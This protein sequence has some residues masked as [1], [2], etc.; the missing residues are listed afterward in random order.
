P[1]GNQEVFELRTVGGYS[2]KLTGDH[3]VW[4]RQRGFVAARDLNNTDEVK[5]PSSTAAVQEIG[6]PRDERFFQ[7]LGLF[8]AT[9]NAPAAAGRCAMRLDS[10]LDDAD[11]VAPLAR[12]VSQTWCGRSTYDDDY[13]NQLMLSDDDSAEFPQGPEG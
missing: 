5:L 7:L 3:K 10:C 1:T 11:L 8:I 4:T 2:V 9:A 6:Q 12:Y 13:V